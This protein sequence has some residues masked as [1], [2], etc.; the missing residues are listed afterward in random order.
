MLHR[1]IR[2]STNYNSKAPV[3][4]VSD[5]RVFTQLLIIIKKKKYIYIYKNNNKKN[6]NT[7]RVG[8][9]GLLLLLCKNVFIK[10]TSTQNT[11]RLPFLNK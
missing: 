11:S 7:F 6:N 3:L 2:I 10:L 1:D 8:I 9:M 5:V 4:N